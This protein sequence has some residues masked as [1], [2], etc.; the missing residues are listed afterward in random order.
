MPQDAFTANPPAA[1]EASLLSVLL[2]A[3]SARGGAAALLD[4]LRPAL[5]D[6]TCA[7]AVRDRDGL[8]LVVLAETGGPE[9]WPSK[10][11]PQLAM[12]AKHGVDQTTGAMVVPL[13]A[14]GRV[15]GALLFADAPRAASIIPGDDFQSLL[16]T[17]AAVLHVLVS[18]IDAELRRRAIALRSID[19]VIDGMA[20]QMANPL[21]GASAIAQLLVDDVQ[22]EAH[23]AAVNQIR[24]ELAR[25]FAVLD[26][27]LN[28]QRDTHAQDGILDLNHVAERILRFRG[29]AIREQGIDLV[30]E[31][32]AMF[33]PVRAD[34]RGLE[35]AVIVAL[36]HAELQS[37]GTVNRSINVRVAERDE[38]EVVIEITDSGAGES[39][40]V[41]P[42]Y[43]DLLFHVDY[44]PRA[45]AAD[46]PDLGLVDSVLRGCG[47]R[48]EIHASKA[49]GTTLSLVLPR[50]YTH[51]TATSRTHV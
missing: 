36:R 51:S 49:D 6:Q 4:A 16:Q 2:S 38:A 11:E 47:G 31:Q 9:R 22:D 39:P 41:A 30:I 17:T 14:N 12:G 32:S 5:D 26:D 28:F 35:H 50:A 23:R 3:E 25:A 40:P 1:I 10:L 27:I 45:T 18:R 37:H 33:L 13:R 34:A 29:Y 42:A 24:Q 19:V 20:H 7:L 21:T 44:Q 43:F 15:V 46:T 8:T 48:L